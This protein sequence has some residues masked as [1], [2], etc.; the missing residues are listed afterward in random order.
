MLSNL[1]FNLSF[2]IYNYRTVLTQEIRFC[3]EVIK[4]CLPLDIDSR[5]PVLTASVSE[6][7]GYF[8]EEC[9]RTKAVLIVLKQCPTE[10]HTQSKSNLQNKL[11]NSDSYSIYKIV[12]NC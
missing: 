12:F 1:S 5:I 7:L 2:A 8:P 6:V 10:T 9:H 4:S 3:P 11:L